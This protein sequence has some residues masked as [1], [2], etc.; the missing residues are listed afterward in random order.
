MRMFRFSL[1]L[2]YGVFA[3]ESTDA[4]VERFEISSRVSFANGKTFGDIGAYERI[5]GTVH[6][7]LDPNS[8]QNNNVVDL[9]L[10]PRDADGLVRYT[11]DVSLLAPVDL[12]KASGALLYDVNNRGNKLALNFFNFGD[13]S[14][15]NDPK[16]NKHAGDGFLMKQG[17]VVLWSGWI[18]ELLPGNNRLRLQPPST[19][20]APKTIKGRVRYELFSSKKTSTLTVNGDGHGVYQPADAAMPKAWLTHRLKPADPRIYIP[21][22][23]WKAA[24]VAATEDAPM[25]KM[26]VTLDGGFEPSVLYE[27]IYQAKNPVVMGTSFT[28]VRDLISAFKYGD[29]KDNPLLLKNTPIVERAHGF[30]VS[31]SGRFLRELVYWGL[32]ED[33]QGRKAFDAV[34]PH[35]S[36]GGLG[37]FN[38]R[39]CQ[40][41]AYNTQFRQ[42]DYPSDRFPFAYET[43]T[44][45]LSKLTDGILKRSSKSAMP[46]IFHTQSSSEYWHR[47]GSLAHTDTLG[48]KDS[49][50][51]NNVRIYIFGGTQHGPSTFPPSTSGSTNKQNPGD[52]RYFLRSLLVRLDR[53]VADGKEPPASVYPTIA[54]GNLVAPHQKSSGFPTIPGVAYPKVWQQ[55]SLWELGNRWN[56]HRIIDR[57]PPLPV[58][59]YVVLVPRFNHDGNELGCLNPPE[60]EVPVASYTGWNLIKDGT[61][62][63]GN[64]AGLR[65]SYIPFPRTKAQRLASKDP[66]LSVQERYDSVDNYIDRMAVYCQRLVKAGYLMKSDVPKI[67]KIHRQRTAKLFAP[68]E[69]K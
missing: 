49:E 62:A 58:A 53:W 15:R 40:P 16:S 26:T 69:T 27:L 14:N 33:E 54:S 2:L 25:S 38:Y 18:G 63:D 47:S 42:H 55:P 57:E 46:Y 20:A 9:N 61:V 7:T 45:S 64:L 1:V 32:N 24:I 67:L 52:Y 65:G 41:T 12:S 44:D 28:S 5:E 51:P 68:V 66:R 4:A 29:G 31:Q 43:Q 35:V 17:I 22:N 19:A 30:G 11:A 21:R 56:E 6:F 60:V 39:F 10:A 34:I 23:K 37:S 59:D 36:G 8:P 50:V 48:R 3:V 13:H